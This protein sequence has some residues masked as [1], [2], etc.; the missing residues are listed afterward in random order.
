MCVAHPHFKYT[1]EDINML[2]GASPLARFIGVV[3]GA[4]P[5]CNRIIIQ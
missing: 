1:F 4:P 3:T 5:S 2:G